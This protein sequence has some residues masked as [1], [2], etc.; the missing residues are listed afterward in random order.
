MYFARYD[1]RKSIKVCITILPWTNLEDWRTWRK[2]I[3]I[4]DDCM[5]DNVLHKTKELKYF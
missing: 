1:Y 3:L 2:T 5:L 4:V